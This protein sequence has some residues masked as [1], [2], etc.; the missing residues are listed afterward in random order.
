[1]TMT[2]KA[3]KVINVLRNGKQPAKA[4]PK[5]ILE[6]LEQAD[7]I[8]FANGTWRLTGFNQFV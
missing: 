7:M 8:F 5:W 6:G 3:Q 4:T 2:P 1:M